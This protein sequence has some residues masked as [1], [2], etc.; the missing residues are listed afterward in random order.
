MV[1]KIDLE[2]IKKQMEEA[3]AELQAHDDWLKQRDEYIDVEIW[4]I[5]RVIYTAFL[6]ITIIAA[7]IKYL[8][9]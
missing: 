7:A 4:Q 2:G 5:A 8:I 3:D 9:S 1:K 6:H